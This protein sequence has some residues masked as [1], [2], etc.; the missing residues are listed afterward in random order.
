MWYIIKALHLLAATTLIGSHTAAYFY[1]MCNRQHPQ[2]LGFVIEH[3]R[4]TYRWILFPLMSIPLASATFMVT[5][6]TQ[7]A[8]HTPW[9]VVAYVAYI[10]LCC[11]MIT[12]YVLLPKTIKD[13][14]HY[15]LP[16]IRLTLLTAMI[17]IT[18]ALIVRDA[19]HHATWLYKP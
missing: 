5:T 4:K 8:F 10:L 15:Q 14:L 13:P 16:K 1:L 3:A 19:V 18:S 11:A 12:S 2:T 6:N 17:L 7:L 9:I